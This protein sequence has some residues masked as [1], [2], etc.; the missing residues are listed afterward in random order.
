M[1]RNE[2]IQLDACTD[3][4]KL[5]EPVVDAK[6][7]MLLPDGAILTDKIITRLLEKNIP[8]V[9]IEVI[10]HVSEE[11]QQQHDLQVE[12]TVKWRFRKVMESKLMQQLSD[13]LIEYQSGN[14]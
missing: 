7:T 1:S 10:E 12:E 5:A 4:M 6:G 11:E 13:G 9:C 14:T 2:I 8:S 3:G